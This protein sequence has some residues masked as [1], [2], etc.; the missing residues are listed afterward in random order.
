MQRGLEK[1]GVHSDGVATTSIAGGIRTDRALP[2]E[3]KQVMQLSMQH[4]Y[5]R[6]LH[7]VASGRN[8]PVDKIAAIAEGRVWSG[9]DAK[10]LGLVDSLGDLDDATKAAARLAGLNRLIALCV[11]PG[12]W[13]CAIC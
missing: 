7:I 3:L 9:L 13:V 8:M 5:N 11:S 6:F 1:L 12:H 10:R 4:I 2:A